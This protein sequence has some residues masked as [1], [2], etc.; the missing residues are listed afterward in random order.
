MGADGDSG[1]S[2]TFLSETF[3][4]VDSGNS[5]NSSD[6]DEDFESSLRHT[7]IR[8]VTGYVMLPCKGS[9]SSHPVVVRRSVFRLHLCVQIRS[10]KV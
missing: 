2:R 1:I 8:Q 6:S 10:W 7:G 4:D 9:V 3:S 5:S